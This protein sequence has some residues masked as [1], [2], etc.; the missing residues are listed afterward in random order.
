MREHLATN[1]AKKFT[2][3]RLDALSFLEDKNR[4]RDCSSL[5]GSVIRS[6]E[7]EDETNPITIAGVRA[8]FGFLN[9]FLSIAS[10]LVAIGVRLVQASGR[11]PQ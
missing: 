9:S 7:V 10:A 4:V 2:R 6:L 8:S 11:A 3:G 5:I 1:R